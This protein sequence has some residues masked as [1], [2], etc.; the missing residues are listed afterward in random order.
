MLR[1][2]HI[3]WILCF[4]ALNVGCQT[5]Q[6]DRPSAVTEKDWLVD[7]KAQNKS[8]S[9]AE[10]VDLPLSVLWEYN[11]A[12]AFGP[13]SPLLLDDVVLVGT[14]KGE[15]HA[16][17]LSSGKK[18][19]YRNFGEGI[20]ATSAINKGI[21]FVPSAMGKHVL[22]A[23][24]LAKGNFLWRNGGTPIES[25]LV[26]TETLVIVA[27]IQGVV[28]AYN[29]KDG[30]LVWEK[31]L[32]ERVS[33]Q[34]ALLLIDSEAV[35]VADDSG[36]ATLISAQ[37]GEIIWSRR[38]S[39]PVYEGAASLGNKIVVPTTR[40]TIEVLDTSSGKTIW[41]YRAANEKIRFGS[42]AIS[43]EMVV[44]GATDGIVRAF[45][46]ST[47]KEMWSTDFP[48]VITAA[49]LIEKQWV[50]VG[51]YGRKLMALDLMDGKVQWETTLRGRM[52]SAM[53]MVNDGLIVLSEPRYITY[54]KPS[55]A[56]GHASN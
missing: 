29:Q 22:V 10:G 6:F 54:F 24:N 48:D 37:T 45:E 20:E 21:L 41:Q 35:F 43:N 32:G 33:V 15:I 49:P 2:Q 38:L 42:P 3:V 14:M 46:A 31:D 25:G 55:E 40:G 47:G 11:A 19:G 28:K 7:G 12:S 8:R 27:D 9:T 13:G 44:V 51:T 26:I 52:K 30:N 36:L 34:S 39:G 18:R 1:T 17:E 56:P 50:F 23:F 5:I 53:A 16:V 4:L